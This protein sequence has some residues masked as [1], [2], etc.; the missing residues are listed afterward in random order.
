[1]AGA[2][3]RP[4]YRGGYYQGYYV[5]YTGRR[6]WFK[7]A[8]NRRDT[9]ELARKLEAEHGEVR[10][11]LREPHHLSIRYRNKSFADARLEYLKWGASHGGR[12]NLPWGAVH[13][14][15]R[16]HDLCWWEDQAS[17][18]TLGDLM[19]ILPRVEKVLNK[20]LESGRTGKTASNRAESLAAFCR[21]C[22]TRKYLAEYPLE[23]LR[24]YRT[25]SPIT[26]RPMEVEEVRRL[27][28]CS[29][30][31][32]RI[33]YET[34]AISGL[35]AN[36]LRS[37]TVKHLDAERLGVR[38]DERWTKNRKS[39]FQYLGL[40]LTKRL[41]AFGE[42]GI[43]QDLYVRKHKRKDAKPHW[44]KNPLLY[45][46][47]HPAR[48]FDRDLASAGIEKQTPDGK[49]DFHALRVAMT[50]FVVETGANPKEAQTLLRHSTPQLT[51]NLYAKTRNARLERIIDKVSSDLLLPPKSATGVLAQEVRDSADQLNPSD[52]KD[53]DADQTGGGGGNRTRVRRRLARSFYMLSSPCFLI[54]WSGSEHAPHRTSPICFAGPLRTSGAGYPAD[55][56]HPP[57]QERE[58]DGMR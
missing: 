41:W 56:V 40:E 29:P 5:D 17:I 49:L 11:G 23:G 9:K 32:R 38:L 4:T 46:P 37:L 14:R 25:V 3:K 28:I 15:N 45:V 27:L 44:P 12:N 50:T 33:L 13:A 7:G 8:K 52:D 19:G 47:S 16:Q 58:V 1:M 35:R 18:K 26:R 53:L 20:F 24:P 2:R 6:V 21:W 36:E 34:A 55:V 39:G 42:A 48:E 51:M 54:L 10:R 31:Y 57:T 22:V 30:Y 43:A